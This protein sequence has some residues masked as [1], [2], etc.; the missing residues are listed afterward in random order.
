MFSRSPRDAART[1]VFFGGNDAGLA[2]DMM[3]QEGM[4]QINLSLIP[5]ALL[6]SEGSVFQER[7]EDL[8]G[9]AEV[10]LGWILPFEEET[11]ADHCQ[12]DNPTIGQEIMADWLANRFGIDERRLR[13]VSLT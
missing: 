5:I 1:C 13:D 7:V 8:A 12:H 9:P 2:L 10:I 3:E 6:A 4:E 11:G